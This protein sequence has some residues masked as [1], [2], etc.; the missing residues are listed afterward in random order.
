M[1]IINFK[2]KIKKFYFEQILGFRPITV[3]LRHPINIEQE[4]YLQNHKN[5]LNLQNF[6]KWVKENFSKQIF[7]E[8][9]FGSG[10]HV[11]NLA[12][13]NKQNE[14]I[15]IVGI[16]L[17]KPGVVK[18]LRKIDEKNLQNLFLSS[19]DVRDILKEISLQSLAKIFILFPDPWT[20]KRQFNRRLVNENFLKICLQ[21]LKA[22]GEIILATDWENYAEEIEKNLENLKNKREIDFQ[23]ISD[24][25]LNSQ[26]FQNICETAFAKRAKREGR[27]INIFIIEKTKTKSLFRKIFNQFFF[28]FF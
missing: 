4:N 3:V 1:L 16:E 19:C 27:K 21:K 10:E 12:D 20:K 28:Y 7:L 18:A 26:E 8:I 5:F 23:T 24:E 22:D 25:S 17:Y 13:E 6:K 11:V 14:N 9:G 2:K 15:K